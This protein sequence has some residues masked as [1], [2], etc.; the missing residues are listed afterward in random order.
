MIGWVIVA[1]VLGFNMGVMITALVSAR[2]RRR[3]DDTGES[4]GAGG[5]A[6][7]E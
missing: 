6:E 1:W 2:E 3:K 4:D 7:A 5:R